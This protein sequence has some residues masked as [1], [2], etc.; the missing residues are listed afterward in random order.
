M[1]VYEPV[2]PK[3][4]LPALDRRVLERWRATRAFER[5][6]EQRE[7]GPEWVFYDG[8]PTAN[9]RPHIGHAEAR[10]FKDLYPRYRAMTGHHVIR[11]AG[12]D[13]H[14]LPVELEVEKEIGTKTKQDIEAFGIAEFNQRCRE[15]VVRYVDDW[16][17]LVDRIGHWI[18]MDDPYWTMATE[19]VES[20]WWSLKT[21]F[22]QGL[23]FEDHKSVAYCP[24]CQTALSDAEVAL[25]YE[26]VLDPGVTV[27]FPVTEPSSPELA[28]AAILAWTT[29]P[30]TLPSNEGLAVDP[31]EDYAVVDVGGELLVAAA[32][33]KEQVFRGEGR[34]VATVP[35]SAV[36]GTRYSPPFENVDANAH[37][38]VA[39]DFVVMNEGTG[40]V[41]I[42]PGYGADDLEIGR[43]E[44][45]PVFAPVDDAGRFTDHVPQYL[46][47]R[48]VKETDPDIAEDLRGRGL[49]FREEPYEHTYPLC[50]RCQTPLLYMA[51]TSWY[52]RTTAKKERLLEVNE[53]VNWFPGH[54]KH[55]RYGD[56]LRNNVD[57][58][59]SRSRYWGTPLPIWRCERRHATA[60]GSLAELG[61]R[62]GRDL[63]GL[64][65]HRP[66]IDEVTFACPE[67]GEEARR[68]PEVVDAWFDS[69]AMPYAQWGYHPDL[70]RA[71][72]TFRD[73]FPS[74]FIAEG[75]DQT[76]GWF[77]SLMAG[78]CCCS[79]PPPTGT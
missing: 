77:Y 66:Y 8:P 52:V 67:C 58:A 24:R 57:W 45:W 27:K 16:K 49:L 50:W 12:W 74:D 20:E 60:V 61:E 7:G 56:W 15:S 78:A 42:A 73:R 72:D 40:V 32:T 76:R 38:V 51:R 36:V 25:G 44:G 63:G 17:E 11:K 75:L 71:V 55:G 4:D 29:T 39:A 64:D 59:L 70:G 22:E 46:R 35:G 68:V 69:G 33:L 41:H 23:L 19:Y 28:G 10:T 9:G 30:W 1:T 37:R 65:P 47:G 2:D 18:D 48:P 14:G 62:A 6:V 79:T 3:L 21:L 31:D 43:R 54:I 53:S 13:C 26:T 34:V 5:S